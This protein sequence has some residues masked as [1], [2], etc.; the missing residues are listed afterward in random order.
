MNREFLKGLG[1]DDEQIEKAMAEH[2]KTVN[3]AKDDLAS[4]TTE[5]D[6]LKT[7][8]TDRDTQLT[9]LGKK[10]KD[11]EELTAEID[12]LKTDNQTATTE[13][14]EK[15]DKQAF[16]FSLEKALASAKARNTKSVIANLDLESIKLDG[17]KLL[18]L[19]DQLKALQESDAYLFAD[20]EGTQKP[21]NFTT[22]Q[23]QKGDG[24]NPFSKDNFNLTEQT[25]LFR[26]DPARYE[27]FKAIAK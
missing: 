3:K 26:E 21:P 27:Q 19:D 6:N 5:R 24:V 23:H 10:V 7:Q 25:R 15:L 8:L 20:D 18:G 12:R 13:L 14:Q 17:D 22:G 4:V 2:G 16:D 11:N 9:D 1:L